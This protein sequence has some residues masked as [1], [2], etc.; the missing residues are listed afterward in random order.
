MVKAVV[1]HA[2][3]NRSAKN[4]PNLSEGFADMT[5]DIVLSLSALVGLGMIAMATL[6]GWDGWL[7]LKRLE[8]ERA[9]ALAE[10]GGAA[11]LIDLADMRERLRKLEAIAAGVDL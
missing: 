9:D 5:S 6:R 10:C 1:C 4:N 2:R 3:S 7:A 8:L 11:S